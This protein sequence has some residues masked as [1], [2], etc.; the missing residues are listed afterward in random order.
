LWATSEKESYRDGLKALAY[1]RKAVA[2][3][4]WKDA[5]Y[6]DT[7]AAANAEAGNFTEAVRW[8]RKALAFPDF[9]KSEGEGAKA[10]VKLYKAHKPYRNKQKS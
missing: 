6:I 7:L 4:K 5:G 8:Q 3:T 2:L 10:R 1:A 9:M